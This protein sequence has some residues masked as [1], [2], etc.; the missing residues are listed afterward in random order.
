MKK[1]ITTGI[2]A[3][4][5]TFALTGYTWADENNNREETALANAKISLTQAINNALAVVSG[6]AVSAELDDENIPPVY[7]VEIMQGEN[8]YE[9]T[10]DTQ[11]GAVLRKQM[12]AEDDE[13]SHKK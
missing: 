4:L 2:V 6:K 7:V 5:C 8:T 11:E 1:V 3:L 12:D 10:L 9:V 13:D